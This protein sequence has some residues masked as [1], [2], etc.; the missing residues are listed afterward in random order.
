M[1]AKNARITAINARVHLF[2]RRVHFR[3]PS[4]WCDA[5][6]RQQQAEAVKLDPAIAAN[7]KE[8]GF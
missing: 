6:R 2:I 1:N 5:L 3:V 7:L 4:A 8:L